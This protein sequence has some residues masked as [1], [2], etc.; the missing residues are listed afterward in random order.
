VE[1]KKAF[2][3]SLKRLQLDYLDL[4]LIHQ[5]YGDVYGEWRAMEALYREGKVRAIGV[6]NF[7]P[8]RLIDLI[9]HNEVIPAVNQLETHPFHQQ[10]AAQAFLQEN[11]VQME[12]WGPFAEGKNDEA[13]KIMRGVADKQDALGKGEVEIVQLANPVEESKWIAKRVKLLLDGGVQPSEIIV[14]VQRKRAARIILSAL[15]EAQVPAKSYYE[16]S[17]LETEKS[18]KSFDEHADPKEAKGRG[19]KGH[20]IIK[21]TTIVVVKPPV[22]VQ[23]LANAEGGQGVN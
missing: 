5:P 6:S 15:K 16:E 20:Q 14:L 12:S 23:P 3:N 17:Q 22:T 11:A 19:G 18:G 13:A 1:R 9:I 7:Y 21:R 4:Y 10:V 8:D 2:E